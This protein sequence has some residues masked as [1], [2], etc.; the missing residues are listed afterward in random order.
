MNKKKRQK[1]GYN[2]RKLAEKEFGIQNVI[3]KNNLIYDRL[4]Q[5]EK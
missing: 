5:N 1:F 4:I 3:N 2:G